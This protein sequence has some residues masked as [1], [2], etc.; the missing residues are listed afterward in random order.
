MAP[1]RHKRRLLLVILLASV[2]EA[3]AAVTPVN[4]NGPRRNEPPYPVVLNENP[5]RRAAAATAWAQL[6]NEKAANQPAITLQ[7]VTATI[8]NLPESFSTPLYLPK[9]GTDAY[10]SEEQT[11]ESLRRFLNQSQKLI[12]ADPSQL[13]LVQQATNPDGTQTAV[14]DQRPFGYPLRGGYGKIEIRFT[15]DRRVLSLSSTAIPEAARIQASLNAVKPTIKEEEIAKQLSGKTLSYT[16]AAGIKRTYAIAAD[17]Q[18]SAQQ[19][20]VYPV[21][22]PAK[23]E[24]DFHLAWEVAP[25]NA[26]VTVIYVDAVR[27]E[28]LPAW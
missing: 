20:V 25:T 27:G 26:P 19:L 17:N 21:L 23:G 11:R 24:L 12:G 28:V 2:A 18:I 14:Y 5:Q 1:K 6:L 3:C 7:P 22:S 15:S 13:S 4:P 9:V 16:D 8:R 10:M